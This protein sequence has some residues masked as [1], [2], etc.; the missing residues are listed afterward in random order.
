MFSYLSLSQQICGET[1]ALDV[2]I[3]LPE[4][5]DLC[6]RLE[7]WMFSY[8]SLTQQICGETGALDV[9]IS[10]PDSTDLCQ[11][12]E[13]WMFSYL[14]LT[15]QI[16]G[17]LKCAETRFPQH[18]KTKLRLGESAESSRCISLPL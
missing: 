9:L 4:S 14:S 2:L 11:R 12:L 16:C 6:Q 3:S 13:P 1:G 8:L 5:T 17:E 10:L 15:Q 7:P 18:F